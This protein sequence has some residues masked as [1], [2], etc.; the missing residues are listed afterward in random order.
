MQTVASRD[1]LLRETNLDRQLSDPDSASGYLADSDSVKERLVPH[2]SYYSIDSIIA[3]TAGL[4]RHP[5]GKL[6]AGGGPPRGGRASEPSVH[7]LEEAET[8]TESPGRPVPA[9]DLEQ[10]REGKETGSTSSAGGDFDA[11]HSGR[12]REQAYEAGM[13]GGLSM[14]EAA[15]MHHIDNAGSTAGT[16]GGDSTQWGGSD[17]GAGDF[18]GSARSTGMHADAAASDADDSQDAVSVH[19]AHSG[20]DAAK[21]HQNGAHTEAD[22]LGG[23]G[24]E[25]LSHAHSSS[26]VSSPPA[27]KP[28]DLPTGEHLRSSADKG[29]ET[30]APESAGGDMFAGLMLNG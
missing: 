17:A 8:E 10:I 16:L 30:G 7:T 20:R 15:H 12:D 1:A 3:G 6:P 29:G 5:S 4:A 22:M 27:I 24:E 25:D 21:V 9:L 13:F 14:A 18:L 26:S 28:L 2:G 19:G 11:M 23:R